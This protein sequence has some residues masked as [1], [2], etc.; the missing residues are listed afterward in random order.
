MGIRNKL[1]KI[2]AFVTGGLT[3]THEIA[4]K[5]GDL[6]IRL[7]RT[8]DQEEKEKLTAEREALFKKAG[9]DA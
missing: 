8:V 1:A 5:C 3:E 7:E 4:K 9:I 6:L 2:T